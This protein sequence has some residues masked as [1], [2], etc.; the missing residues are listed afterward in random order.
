MFFILMCS[1]CCALKFFSILVR[2]IG[3]PSAFRSQLLRAGEG[4]WL[5]KGNKGRET[6]SCMGFSYNSIFHTLFLCSLE[7][8]NALC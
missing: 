7:I 6:T 1:I 8:A 2:L 5:E 3:S 4:G